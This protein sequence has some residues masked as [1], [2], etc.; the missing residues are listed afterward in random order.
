MNCH[1]CGKV[2]DPKYPKSRRHCELSHRP[3]KKLAVEL[4]IDKWGH[5]FGGVNYAND[6]ERPKANQGHPGH[7]GE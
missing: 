1:V 6:R 7:G 5:S 4:W 2:L 3:H